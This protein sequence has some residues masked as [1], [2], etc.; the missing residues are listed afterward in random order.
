MFR[1]KIATTV[2]AAGIAVVTIASSAS[3]ASAYQRHEHPFYNKTL[4][5]ITQKEADSFCNKMAW[6]KFRQQQFSK[7][8]MVLGFSLGEF[9]LYGD[10]ATMGNVSQINRYIGISFS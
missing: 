6:A 7:L 5:N 8:M 2:A 3:P 1:Q 4:N 9:G 10:I